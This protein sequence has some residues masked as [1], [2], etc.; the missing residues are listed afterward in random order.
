M[1]NELCAVQVLRLFFFFS[2]AQNYCQLAGR[3]W[4]RVPVPWTTF[5]FCL[6]RFFVR[7]SLSI[8][9]NITANSAHEKNTHTNNSTQDENKQRVR[10]LK[11]FAS[12]MIETTV[13]EPSVKP[14]TKTNRTP[15]TITMGRTH[16][17]GV[18]LCACERH[19]LGFTVCC[20]SHAHNW[21]AVIACQCERGVQ[22]NRAGL[23]SNVNLL[24]VV[25]VVSYDDYGW[26]RASAL[27]HRHQFCIHTAQSHNTFI[28]R[29][30]LNENCHFRRIW[31]DR[32]AST[33]IEQLCRCAVHPSA[34]FVSEPVLS[35]RAGKCTQK[36]AVI[37]TP[38]W[39]LVDEQRFC[40]YTGICNM[41]VNW[42]PV[43]WHA[44]TTT[45]IQT[46]P[47]HWMLCTADQ[48]TYSKLLVQIRFIADQCRWERKVLLLISL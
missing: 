1:N 9:T 37:F 3:V 4:A 28:R 6:R 43:T 2:G 42:Q 13:S 46:L 12:H 25:Y 18:R 10:A 16:V 44:T 29:S 17:C 41:L 36:I 24:C 5:T 8:D 33:R 38:P 7:V 23:R 11:R 19:G 45:C 15:P 21:G 32:C 31:S 22:W 30:G 27:P 47:T 39:V 20:N 40:C 35:A 14:K 26:A 48:R 34:D